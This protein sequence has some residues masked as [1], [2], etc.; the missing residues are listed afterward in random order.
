[1]GREDGE[2]ERSTG[3]GDESS[4]ESGVRT[5]RK[6]HRWAAKGPVK[7]AIQARLL[8]WRGQ[9]SATSSIL[10]QACLGPNFAPPNKKVFDARHVTFIFKRL[11]IIFQS[12]KKI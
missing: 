7:R 2:G 1:V 10:G 5:R 8:I 3:A 9:N 4:P 11:K 6:V 12:F